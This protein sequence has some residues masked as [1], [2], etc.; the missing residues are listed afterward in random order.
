MF[1]LSPL[2][3]KNSEF[4][5]TDNIN[6]IKLSKPRSLLQGSQLSS[7]CPFFDYIFPPVNLNAIILFLFDQRKGTLNI[8]L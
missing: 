8:R 3:K 6:N 2:I 1:N 4:Q 7:A 5:R